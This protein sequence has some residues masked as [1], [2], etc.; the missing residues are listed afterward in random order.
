MRAY[1]GAAELLSYCNYNY[2]GNLSTRRPAS[3][4]GGTSLR[5]CEF[6]AVRHPPATSALYRGSSLI[7][8]HHHESSSL[9]KA[10]CVGLLAKN[11]VN[12]LIAS[13][14]SPICDRKCAS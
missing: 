2:R 12:S 6:V 5:K 10:R 9:A 7:G 4:A 1:E 13:S 14:L 3:I 8:S 11:F